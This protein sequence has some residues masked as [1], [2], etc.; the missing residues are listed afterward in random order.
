MPGRGEGLL[1]APAELRAL[2]GPGGAELRDTGSL[3]YLRAEVRA[4]GQEIDGGRVLDALVLLGGPAERHGVL[5]ARMPEAG[6]PEPDRVE[7]ARIGEMD[8]HA[9]AARARVL[10]P[11]GRE[12]AGPEADAGQLLGAERVGESL[13]VEP[14]RAEQLEGPRRP[15]PFGEI[16][17]LEQAHARV[18]ERGVRTRHVRRGHHPGQ[19]GLAEVPV[20]APAAHFD[21]R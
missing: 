9:V 3:V 2:A 4:S 5:R 17:P 14:G 13:G 6:E 7:A 1:A 11:G 12:G 8:L 15:A 19:A 20:A 18:D 21:D 16:G 10:V